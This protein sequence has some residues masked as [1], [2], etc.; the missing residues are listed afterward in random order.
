MQRL[1]RATLT[2]LYWRD[3]FFWIIA[4]PTGIIY[5]FISGFLINLIF[6]PF[7]I[8]IALFDRKKIILPYLETEFLK[9]E[10]FTLAN[11]VSLYGLFLCGQILNWYLYWL[12]D[13]KLP[14]IYSVSAL[15]VHH[16]P[17]YPAWLFAWYMMETFLTDIIDGPL[18]RLNM[19]VTALGTFLDH[20]RDYTAGLI[21]FLLLITLTIQD[22]YVEMLI[23]EIAL[24]AGF[25]GIFI[26]HNKL[27]RLKLKTHEFL[28]EN[29]WGMIK[30]KIEFLKN[31]ALNEYQTD[32]LGRIQFASAAFALSSGLFYFAA[33][34]DF[35]H[36]AF[37]SSMTL[38]LATTCF[39]MY[40]LW[41]RHM[42]KL[43]ESMQ[44]KSDHMK[45]KLI[46]KTIELKRGALQKIS[47]AEKSAKSDKEKI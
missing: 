28:N 1:D 35:I 43:R 45:E 27:F 40:K 7:V 16:L 4:R 14:K 21:S 23:P 6:S 39:Y 47:P 5:D 25:L 9:K 2:E 26:Y 30:E 38:S 12:L 15:F 11:L 36:I 10:I 44:A 37:I 18:A 34:N 32:L 24:L 46:D 8:F 42:E 20:F 41:G 31:F 22:G 29:F 17:Y 19:S 13:F 3:F 33:W